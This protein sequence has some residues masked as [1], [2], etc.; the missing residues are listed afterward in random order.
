M[1]WQVR[2]KELYESVKEENEPE[3]ESKYGHINVYLEYKNEKGHLIERKNSLIM[4]LNRFYI[5]KE[6]MKTVIFPKFLLN[7]NKQNDNFD[8][9]KLYFLEARAELQ[10]KYPKIKFV[11]IKHPAYYNVLD[12]FPYESIRWSEL[13]K[14]GFIIIDLKDIKGIDFTSKEYCLPDGHPNKKAWNVVVNYL[15][16]N[17]NF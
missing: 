1:L 6:F 5:V 8:L 13:E 12:P 2:T 17:F 7:K 15:K 4:Q 9:I 16:S 10:K 3:Y 11:I 14:E